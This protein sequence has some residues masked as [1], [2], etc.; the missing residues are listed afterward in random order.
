MARGK[1]NNLETIMFREGLEKAFNDLIYQWDTHFPED[2]GSEPA[3]EEFTK[4]W[5]SW[6][7]LRGGEARQVVRDTS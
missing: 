1:F 3:K 2:P 4:Y 5:M 6:F 7:G